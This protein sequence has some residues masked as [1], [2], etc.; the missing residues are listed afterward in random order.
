[1]ISF[2]LFARISSTFLEN[3]STSFWINPSVSFT[4]TSTNRLLVFFQHIHPV[5]PG[6][7]DAYCGRFSSALA[8]FTKITP[9]FPRQRGYLYTND[10]PVVLRGKAQVGRHNGFSLQGSSHIPTV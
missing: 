2:S 1:M 9:A 7:T 6:V 10:L 5:A 8:F 4:T 3:V